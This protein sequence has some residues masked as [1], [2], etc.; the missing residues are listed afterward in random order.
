MNVLSTE[1]LQRFEPFNRL[2]ESRAAEL[3]GHCAVERVTAGEDPLSGAL[4]GE[5]VYLLSGRLELTDATGAVRCLQPGDAEAASPLPDVGPGYPV[6]AARAVTDVDLTR[7]DKNLLD[8]MLTWDQMTADQ[9]VEIGREVH[10]AVERGYEDSGWNLLTGVFSL[11]NLTTGTFAAMPAAHITSMLHRFE[12]LSVGRGEVIIREGDPGDYYYVINTGRAQVTRMIGGVSM[13]LADLKSGAAFG[14]EALISDTKRNATVTMVTGGTLLRLAKSDFI[15]MLKR[16]LLTEIDVTEAEA[17]VAAGAVWVDVRFP[18]EFQHDRM[19]GAINIPLGE[20]RHAFAGLDKG[21]EYIVYCQ[22]GRRSGA[23][24]FL[25]AQ[26]GFRATVL[27]GGLW[28]ARGLEQEQ[29]QGGK[30]PR[31]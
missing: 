27:S 26:R 8:I 21:V 9:D 12:P 19:P 3:A 25:L 5:A 28:R 6:V 15:E 23:A 14:E 10:G 31:D 20:L 13:P 1:Q 16:P 18:S 29:N 4:P 24:A 11:Q 30:S 2:Q 17:R 7:I 22:S